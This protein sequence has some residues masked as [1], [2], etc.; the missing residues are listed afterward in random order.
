MNRQPI[1]ALLLLLSTAFAGIAAEQG[2]QEQ[3]VKSHR[4]KAEV[5]AQ[6]FGN[7]A[8]Y[9]YAEDLSQ[10]V[11]TADLIVI[12]KIKGE[13]IING[14]FYKYD[15]QGNLS[16]IPE[17]LKNENVVTVHYVDYE[18]QV[19]QTLKDSG[20]NAVDKIV[21]RLPDLGPEADHPGANI[22]IA[23]PQL[24]R[25]KRAKDR[26]LN[27]IQNMNGRVVV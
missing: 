14:E 10:L 15:Q 5:V 20:G 4:A 12:G 11:Q 27:N 19:Q 7:M 2:V 21:L 25:T 1:A 26:G 3:R 9:A 6:Q 18:I 23:Q 22:V 16:G 8:M 17:D 24:D 13:A